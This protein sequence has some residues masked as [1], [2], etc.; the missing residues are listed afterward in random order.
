MGGVQSG[1]WGPVM[2]GWFGA[3]E[4]FDKGLSRGRRGILALSAMLAL[5]GNEALGAPCI[6]DIRQAFDTM[7]ANGRA[8]VCVLTRGPWT[9][10]FQV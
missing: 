5:F 7:K 3:A 6:T 1:V 8:D 10:T 2:F 9:G 4:R